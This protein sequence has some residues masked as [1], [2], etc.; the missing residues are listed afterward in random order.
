MDDLWKCGRAWIVCCVRTIM[1]TF[2]IVG[3]RLSHIDRCW[4]SIL[5]CQAKRFG[6][7]ISDIIY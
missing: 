3:G 6:K 1:L 5:S 2:S 4:G 7:G